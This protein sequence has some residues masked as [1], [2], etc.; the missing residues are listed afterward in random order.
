VSR[1]EALTL[2]DILQAS[3]DVY[4]G[5]YVLGLVGPFDEAEFEEF[6]Q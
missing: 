5:P 3:R 4:A 2:E 6:V 1:I